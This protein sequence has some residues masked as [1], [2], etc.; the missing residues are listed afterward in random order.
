MLRAFKTAEISRIFVHCALKSA[1]IS[2]HNTS[3]GGQGVFVSAVAEVI[4]A[5]PHRRGDGRASQW[6][7]CIVD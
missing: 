5:S 1:V 6:G 2:E 3:Q 7:V 4:R